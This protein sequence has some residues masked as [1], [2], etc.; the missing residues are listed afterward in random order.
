METQQLTFWQRN[1]VMIKAIIVGFLVLVLLIPSA[2]I[3]SLVQE[4]KQRQEEVIQE[5]SSKWALAQTFNGPFLVIPYLQSLPDEKGKV[6][7]YK[8][9]AYFLPEQLIINGNLIPEIRYRSIYKV[10]LYKSDLKISGSFQ[11]VQ[12]QN[13]GIDP[14]TVNWNEV[15]ICF[16][17]SDNRGIAEKVV[18]NWK[19]SYKELEPGLPANDISS[20]GISAALENAQ[21]LQNEAGLFS[22]NLKLNG[23]EQFYFTPLGKQ[24]SVTLNSSW[25]NPAF[26]GK[27]LPRDKTIS[28]KGF[29]AKW[30][31]LHYQREI[32]QSWTDLKPAILESGFGVKL[33]QGTDSYGKSMRSVKYAILF[34]ALTF[35]IYFF[36]ELIKNKS[37]HPL[38]YILVGLALCIFYTLLLSIS[39]YLGFDYAYLIA[40]TATVGLVS[41][42]TKSLFEQWSIAGLFFLYLSLLYSFIYILIQLQD[43]ALLFGSIGL[44]IL[45]AI[46]MY[47]S[48]KIDWKGR[49]GQE[50][51]EVLQ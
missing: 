17:L 41:L 39:E 10:V 47:Y 29:T 37:V 42:Y 13:L 16:G 38:Q 20:T 22:L 45:L 11:P 35:C 25:N 40:A 19:G 36:I 4:R 34:I 9:M 32:P 12:L 43:G 27:Y 14:A 30:E 23:S 46:V 26:D 44:F 48:R 50:K 33:L 28:E 3:Q 6:M 21:A 1:A 31:V 49:G 5:V 15:K 51:N 7:Q 24:T 18:F 2:F 8:R